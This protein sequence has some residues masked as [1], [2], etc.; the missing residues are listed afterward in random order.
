MIITVNEIFNYEHK[1]TSLS[2]TFFQLG[3]Y[4]FFH[5]W[6][7]NE[8]CCWRLN[9]KPLSVLWFSSAQLHIQ[10]LNETGWDL[11]D[12]WEMFSTIYPVSVNRNRSPTGFEIKVQKGL[13]CESP[14]RI[15]T[16]LRLEGTL[17]IIYPPTPPLKAGSIKADCSGTDMTSQVLSVS[18]D[19]DSTISLGK[20]CQCLTTLA[21]N[22]K[23]Q[24]K[25][26]RPPPPSLSYF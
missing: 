14:G 10:L 8:L 5:L 21:G 22:Q 11:L 26:V 25:S 15:T 20:W 16:L 12:F 4:H 1:T 2:K 19:R 3:W 18:K 6:W 9:L 13:F 17:E 23:K 7:E 24:T